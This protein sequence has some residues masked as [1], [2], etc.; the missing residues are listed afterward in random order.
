MITF[1]LFLAFCFFSC[2]FIFLGYYTKPQI[3][4]LAILGFAT[5]FFMG[6]L[7]QF[8]GVEEKVGS[9]VTTVGDVSTIVYDYDVIVDSTSVWVGRWLSIV[10]ALGVALVF[11][12]NKQSG[13]DD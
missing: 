11:T 1:D 4:V 7:L 6:M 13:D 2:V 5:L 3:T 8:G 10:S 12:S 9:V